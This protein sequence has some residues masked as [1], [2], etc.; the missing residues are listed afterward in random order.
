[1]DVWGSSADDEAL[2]EAAAIGNIRAVQ[3]FLRYPNID[4]N[5]RNRVNG[6]TALHWAAKRGNADVVTL[7]LRSGADPSLESNASQT[8]LD[9]AHESVRALFGLETIAEVA[10]MDGANEGSEEGFV[11]NYRANPEFAKLWS[12]PGESSGPAFTFTRDKGEVSAGD[13]GSA[14]SSLPATEN[15]GISQSSS[16]STIVMPPSQ[17]HLSNETPSVSS[18]QMHSVSAEQFSLS[19]AP[20]RIQIHQP[21]QYSPYLPSKSSKRELQVFRRTGTTLRCLGAIV[22]RPGE[23]ITTTIHQISAEMDEVPRPEVIRTLYKHNGVRWFPVNRKQSNVETLNVFFG[24]EDVAII[25]I[26]EP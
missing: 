18:S 5:S 12:V 9:V 23:T 11:P 24:N 4:I 6:W 15:T 16:T 14:G 7:L 19:P 22:V 2:R 13:S 25:E 8:A 10:E 1:M 3:A 21:Q 26:E 20:Q 17:P